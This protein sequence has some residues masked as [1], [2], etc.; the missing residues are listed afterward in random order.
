LLPPPY[1]PD[2]FQKENRVQQFLTPKPAGWLELRAS[3]DSKPLAHEPGFEFSRKKELFSSLAAILSDTGLSD[4]E[5]ITGVVDEGLRV[6]PHS[7]NPM[8]LEAYRSLPF[9]ARLVLLSLSLRNI[10]IE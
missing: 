1:S 7:G 10:L 5:T 3:R 6:P 4:S 2:V 9:N 8:E